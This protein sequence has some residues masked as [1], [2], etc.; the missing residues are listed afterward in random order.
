MLSCG[1]PQDP[2]TIAQTEVFLLETRRFRRR[3]CAS[4]LEA[5]N[6]G[7]L[8]EPSLNKN[9][10]TVDLVSKKVRPPSFASSSMSPA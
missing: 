2:T 3:M 8:E 10:V 5:C 9:R 4:G 1:L 6:P 7:R